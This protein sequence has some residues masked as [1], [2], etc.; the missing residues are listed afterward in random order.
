MKCLNCGKELTGRQT[1]YCSNQC[2]KEYQYKEYIELWKAGKEN[3]M[4]GQFDTSK[5]IK[6]YLIQRANGKCERCGWGEINPYTQKIPL[7]LHHKDGNYRNN[8]EDNLEL[9]CPNCHSLTDTYRGGNTGKSTREGREKYVARKN[10]CVDCGIEIKSTSTRCHSCESK[11][12]ITDK[13]VT[14]EELKTL[15]RTTPFTKIASQFGISDNAIRKWCDSYNLPR[16]V[17]DIKKYS[18]IEWEKI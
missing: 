10:Y 13:P 17:T 15:I 9:L 8:A 7:E 4:R 5:H 6:R 18:D 1:K 3:G 2:Q 16:K 12:R 11:H 14:R